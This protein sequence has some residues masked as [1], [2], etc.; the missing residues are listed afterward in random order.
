MFRSLVFFVVVGFLICAAI[1]L[2]DFPGIVSLEWAGWRIDTS[3]AVLLILVTIFSLAIAL[4]YQF[5]LF[6][7]KSPKKIHAR[8]AAKRRER[9]YRALTRGMVAVAAGDANEAQQQATLAGNLL[10]EPPLTLLV[11][12]QA[13][14]MRGDEDAAIKYFNAMVNRSD[15]KFLGLKGLYNQAIKRGDK[16]EAL[17]LAKRAHRLEPKSTWVA[18]DMCN[19][20]ISNGKWLDA[21][22]S[23]SDLEKLKL[24]DSKTA[25]RQKAI[26]HYQLS[27]EA[28]NKR[29]LISAKNYLQKCIKQA[30]DFIPAII[31]LSADWNHDG[32]SSKAIKLIEKSWE[33]CPH[34]ELIIS[35]LNACG[36]SKSIDKVRV[37]K[38]LTRK[39]PD[40]IESLIALS[41]YSIEAKL[42]GKARQY[43]E[44]AMKKNTSPAS[45]VFRMMA[46]LEKKENADH[47]SAH[48]WLIKASKANADPIW[49]CNNCGNSSNYWAATCGK[50]EKFDSFRW[51]EPYQVVEK[52]K[53]TKINKKNKSQKSPD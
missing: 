40:H 28:R 39:C 49:I 14:Q 5:I 33:T 20:Q 27:E 47:V 7:K 18:N 9:G 22:V 51:G 46:E 10:N 43:L 44:L 21:K 30:P 1:T 31:K 37:I 8:W 17:T 15:T 38:K 23:T 53:A 2:S 4:I 41:Q 32:K 50:C 48:D 3:F 29:D 11:S 12:A 52:I 6:L 19:L 34:P 26:L 25:Q 42:W 36:S 35:Y 16:I 13:A 24:M 45:R